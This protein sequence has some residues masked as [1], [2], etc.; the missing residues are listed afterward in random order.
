MDSCFEKLQYEKAW[1][2]IIMMYSANVRFDFEENYD[3]FDAD[4]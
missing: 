4:K 1:L 2:S 3:H